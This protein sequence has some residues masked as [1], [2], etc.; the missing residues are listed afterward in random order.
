MKISN[1]LILDYE[2]LFLIKLKLSVCDAL[3]LPNI[4]FVAISFTHFVLTL[5]FIS[6]NGV[7]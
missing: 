2:I 1:F 7:Y 3:I 4:P 5:I 6:L